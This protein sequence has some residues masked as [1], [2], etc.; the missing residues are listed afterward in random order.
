VIVFSDWIKIAT[1]KKS[2]DAVAKDRISLPGALT[3]Y[4]IAAAILAVL[5]VLT[6]AFSYEQIIANLNQLVAEF[7]EAAPQILQQIN[8]I[9][10]P[11]AANL[12]VQFVQ[13]IAISFAGLFIGIGIVRLLSKLLGGTGTYANLLVV[14]AV[15]AAAV[16]GTWMLL[17][18]VIELLAAIAGVFMAA[19]AI[20]GILTFVVSVFLWYLIVRAVSVVEG[21][22]MAKAFGITLVPLAI[23]I[24]VVAIW[25]ITTMMQQ[26]AAL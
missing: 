8:M 2:I 7:P 5:G 19:S 26:L 21:F 25:V 24:A 3:Q 22:G 20:I 13:S 12:A 9:P 15:A 11:T 17:I 10:E 14:S 6:I 23:Y 18:S 1:L 4:L 16:F